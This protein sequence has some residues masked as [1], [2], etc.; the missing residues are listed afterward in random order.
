MLEGGCA[1]AKGSQLGRLLARDKLAP[2]LRSKPLFHQHAIHIPSSAP[3]VLLFNLP[4]IPSW[5]FKYCQYFEPRL[6]SS[7]FFRV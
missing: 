2:L 7:S 4:R 5:L 3:L 1:G 6:K